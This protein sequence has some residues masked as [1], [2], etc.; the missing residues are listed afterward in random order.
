MQTLA[1]LDLPYLAMEEAAFARDPFRFMAEARKKHPWLAT[2]KYGLVVHDYSAMRELLSQDE[3]M[4]P[5]YGG[6]VEQLGL[7]GTPWGRFTEEQMISL[8]AAQ[9]RLL[10]DTLVPKFTP[11]S[12]NLMRPMMRETVS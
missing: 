8:P 11:R 9:H 3:K 4:R 2:S 7:R 1:E 12:A 10:R 6:I 5:P